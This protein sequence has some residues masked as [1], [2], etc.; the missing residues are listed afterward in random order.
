MLPHRRNTFW[1]SKRITKALGWEKTRLDRRG[2]SGAFSC[3]SVNKQVTLPFLTQ[4]KN[5][6]VGMPR[7]RLSALENI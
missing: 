7:I 6:R 1:Y 4:I 2:T 3:L 5:G